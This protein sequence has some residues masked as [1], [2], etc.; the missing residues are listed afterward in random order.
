MDSGKGL[1]Q[2]FRYT[3]ILVSAIKKY[4]LLQEFRKYLGRRKPLMTIPNA[5]GVLVM[6]YLRSVLLKL[7]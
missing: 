6:S 5:W 1:M 4:G 7:R 3:E 2:R